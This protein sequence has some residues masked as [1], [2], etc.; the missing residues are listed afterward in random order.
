[1]ERHYRL[2]A[3]C[4]VVNDNGHTDG[5]DDSQMTTFDGG[6]RD[7]RIIYAHRFTIQQEMAHA[8]GYDGTRRKARRAS[9]GIYLDL[10]WFR[11]VSCSLLRLVTGASVE[12]HQWEA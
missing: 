12:S 11:F 2:R 5:T 1:M 7:E 4:I 8:Q 3:V 10:L 9:N 6:P